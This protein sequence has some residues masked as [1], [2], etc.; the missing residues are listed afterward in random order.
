MIVYGTRVEDTFRAGALDPKGKRLLDNDIGQGEGEEEGDPLITKS[1][2][3]WQINF[4]PLPTW[5][6]ITQ[7]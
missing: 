7:S 1:G 6:N 4:P 3:K 5:N 2:L